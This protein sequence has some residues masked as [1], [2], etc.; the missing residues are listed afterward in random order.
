MLYLQKLLFS[1]FFIRASIFGASVDFKLDFS[2]ARKLIA[3]FG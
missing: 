2:A 3:A 1:V